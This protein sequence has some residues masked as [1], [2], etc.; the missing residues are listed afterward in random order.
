MR[1]LRTEHLSD[2]LHVLTCTWRTGF[3][4]LLYGT[5]FEVFRFVPSLLC[6]HLCVEKSLSVL[7]VMGE[8]K[9]VG[10][11]CLLGFH[12]FLMWYDWLVWLCPWASKY[13]QLLKWIKDE[14][15]GLFCCCSQK[16]LFLALVMPNWH[17]N[18]VALAMLLGIQL[19][20]LSTFSQYQGSYINISVSPLCH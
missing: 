18:H 1:N 11:H 12:W 5:H 3:L 2:F 9:L 17:G 8:G 15:K 6:Q 13:Y 10:T 14:L 20:A 19:H 4:M 16:G 7:M